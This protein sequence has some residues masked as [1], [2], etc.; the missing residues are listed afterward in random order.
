M[1]VLYVFDAKMSYGIV[2][3]IYYI[4]NARFQRVVYS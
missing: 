4:N 1:H 2:L 3:I